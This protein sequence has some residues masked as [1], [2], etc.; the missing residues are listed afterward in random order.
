MID[1][2]RSIGFPF[3]IVGGLP[4]ENQGVGYGPTGEDPDLSASALLPR[5]NLQ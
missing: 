3:L 1:G 4:Q 2:H 5:P